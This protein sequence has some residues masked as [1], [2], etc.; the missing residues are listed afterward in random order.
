M[1]MICLWTH[2][3]ARNLAKRKSESSIM[4]ATSK[5]NGKVPV[6]CL[7]TWKASKE[8]TETAVRAALDAGYRGLDTANDCTHWHM[9]FL[10][11]VFIEV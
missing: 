9:L 5:L 11:S 1:V 8:D 10:Y 7:G 3:S 6:L 2:S 4:N